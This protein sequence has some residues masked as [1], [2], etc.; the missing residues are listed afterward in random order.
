MTDNHM[1][2]EEALKQLGVPDD[3]AEVAQTFTSRPDQSSIEG[4][5]QRFPVI[6]QSIA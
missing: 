2:I 6:P 4:I 3:V 5:K 1:D